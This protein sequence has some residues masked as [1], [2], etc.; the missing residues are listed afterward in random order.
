M[1]I[2]N[3]LG[4]AHGHCSNSLPQ[5]VMKTSDHDRIIRSGMSGH[6]FTASIMHRYSRSSVPHPFLHFA[7][8]CPC[9]SPSIDHGSHST[10]KRVAHSFCIPS[11]TLTHPSILE[12]LLL[13]EYML[14][15]IC[16]Q[17]ARFTEASIMSAMSSLTCFLSR[18]HCSANHSQWGW[19]PVLSKRMAKSGQCSLQGQ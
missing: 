5:I 12:L 17:R 19:S 18:V 3:T 15:I 14:C 1:D 9:P 7:H 16:R 6:I 8:P 13:L 11:M 2:H 4:I 10:N